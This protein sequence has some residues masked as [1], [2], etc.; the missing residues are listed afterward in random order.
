MILLIYNA[1][2]VENNKMIQILKTK[3]NMSELMKINIS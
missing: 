3:F 1:K 2:N